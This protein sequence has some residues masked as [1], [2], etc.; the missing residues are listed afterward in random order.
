VFTDGAARGNPGPGGAGVCIRE[1]SGALLAEVA[2]YLGEVT[3]NVAEYRALLLGLEK[4]RA[5]GAR[6]VEVRSDSELLVRQM[7]GEYR[8]RNPGLRELYERAV[9]LEG[10][11]DRVE[12]VHLRR[13]ANRDADRLANRAIDVEKGGSDGQST[14]DFIENN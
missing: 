4:A 9:E 11:F 13:E 1:P 2:R 3:N 10:E 6:Q 7:L 8:V 14:T 5:L 12:Y